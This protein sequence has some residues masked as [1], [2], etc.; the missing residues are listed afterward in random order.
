MANNV[1]VK[2]SECKSQS[3]RD[4]DSLAGVNNAHRIIWKPN[5]F[6]SSFLNKILKK[7]VSLFDEDPFVPLALF[8]SNQK[9][10]GLYL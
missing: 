7:S 4:N 6:F 5:Y 9:W 3:R 1:M 2:L 8:V 10:A